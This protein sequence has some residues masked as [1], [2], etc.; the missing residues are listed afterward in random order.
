M[1]K[2]LLHK[3]FVLFGAILDKIIFT[4]VLV[5]GLPTILYYCVLV[6]GGDLVVLHLLIPILYVVT[7]VVVMGEALATLTAYRSFRRY[8]PQ[9]GLL[10]KWIGQDRQHRRV[11]QAPAVTVPELQPPRSS[12]IVAAYLPNE[13]DI[14]F[15]TLE[16]ILGTIHRPPAGFELILAYN[17]PERLAIE[18]E[19]EAMAEKYPELVLLNVE[20]SRSK[21]ENINEAL[22]IVTGDVTGILDADHRP[23]PDCFERA[24]RWLATGQYAAVQGRNVIRNYNENLLA[25]LIGV[26]FECMYGV[27]H[28]AKSLLV[29]TGMFCGSNGYWRTSIL[30]R[31]KFSHRMLTEDIDATLRALLRGHNIMHDP[32]IITT[33][34]APE[35]LKAFWSQRKRWAQGWLEVALKHQMP[36]IRSR[37]LDG[38]QKVYWSMLLIYSAA[39]HFIALQVFPMFI[40]LTLSQLEAPTV[41]QEYVWFTTGMTLLSGPIQALAAWAVRSRSTKQTFFD[42]VFYCIAIPFYCIFKNVIAIIA[43]Y[44]HFMGDREWVVTARG[45]SNRPA[46]MGLPYADVRDRAS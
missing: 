11:T 21:A 19:L 16:Y 24:W 38:W 46:P 2:E 18:A 1:K 30:R 8:K 4:H 20:G 25:R 33:E 28:P 10:Q 42:Y 32:N 39:F 15:E 37:K 31:V 43:I 17:R 12:L 29:D 27:S 6:N 26:E 22:K 41:A 45:S 35:S 40:G 44:D 9:R 7:S 5:L 13:Q 14:I 3:P 34:L 23:N 36:L